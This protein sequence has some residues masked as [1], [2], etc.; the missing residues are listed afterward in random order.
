MSDLLSSG[1]RALGSERTLGW[2]YGVP[3]SV[4]ET[5]GRDGEGE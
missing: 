2:V 5:Q 4:K 3:L 1:T